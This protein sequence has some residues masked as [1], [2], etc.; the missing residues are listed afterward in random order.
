MVIPGGRLARGHRPLRFPIEDADRL[1]KIL[2]KKDRELTLPDFRDRFFAGGRGA[3][4][5]TRC[6]RRRGT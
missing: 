4:C 1:R 5:P 2:S 3:R 6:W